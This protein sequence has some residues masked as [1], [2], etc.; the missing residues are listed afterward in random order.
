MLI[1][2]LTIAAVLL[3]A[4]SHPALAGDWGKVPE[5]DLAMT[6]LQEDPS[7]DAVFLFDRGE[8]KI[9]E[10]RTLELSHHRRIKILT[11]RG[12][13]YA[14]VAIPVWHEDKVK[15]L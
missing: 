8:L 14:D 12:L 11:D 1:S 4:T 5:E 15:N 9:T 13:K 10:R 7:A 6:Q 2:R 3:A